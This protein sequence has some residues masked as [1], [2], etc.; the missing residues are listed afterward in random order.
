[1]NLVKIVALTL[2]AAIGFFVSLAVLELISFSSFT[3][4][5]NKLLQLSLIALVASGI[6]SFISNLKS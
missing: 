2:I 4:M 6:V 1:M 3:D 5:V